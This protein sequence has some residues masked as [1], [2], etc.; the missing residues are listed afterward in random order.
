MNIREILQSDRD[1]YR[2]LRSI[3]DEE[4]SMWGAAS[5]ERQKLGDYAGKQFDSVINDTRSVILVCLLYTSPSP[6]DS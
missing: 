2:K 1:D 3:L 4:S 6:R 5:G